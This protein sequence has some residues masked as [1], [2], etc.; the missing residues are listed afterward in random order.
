MSQ[1]LCILVLAKTA[2]ALRRGRVHRVLGHHEPHAHVERCFGSM[3]KVS[4]GPHDADTSSPSFCRRVSTSEPF[5]SFR[6]TADEEG[7]D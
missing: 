3:F 5:G 4:G 2:R 1:Y 7:R 6:H